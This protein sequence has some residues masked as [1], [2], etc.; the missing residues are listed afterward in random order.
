MFMNEAAKKKISDMLS[1]K[2]YPASN[3]VATKTIAA[4]AE[5]IIVIH[6]VFCGYDNDPTGGQISV[7][8]PV[9]TVIFKQ[10][11]THSGPCIFTMSPKPGVVGQ[12]V[13]VILAAG[14]SGVVG[15]LDFDYSFEKS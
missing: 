9:G 2:H 8:S 5:F 11:I 12:A 13:K 14:G 6:K 4:V 1:E 15:T 10:P 7:E 3:T